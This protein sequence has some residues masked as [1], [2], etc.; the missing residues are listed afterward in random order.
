[1]S[2]FSSEK[3]NKFRDRRGGDEREND[4]GT[5][6]KGGRKRKK[7]NGRIAK[8]ARTTWTTGKSISNLLF[9]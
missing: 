8:T 7:E 5:K 2:F 4:W 1:M 3:K 9:Q 6:K